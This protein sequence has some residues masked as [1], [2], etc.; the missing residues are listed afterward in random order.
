MTA[1]RGKGEGGIHKRPDGRWEVR[2][3]LGFVNSKRQRKSVYG[4]TRKEV[5]D[6]L[7]VAHN[8]ATTEL[9]WSMSG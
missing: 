4:R 2:L 6:K 5:A 8:S 9:S 7:R 3:D 1:R